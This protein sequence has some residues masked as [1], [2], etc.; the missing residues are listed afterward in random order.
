MAG[1]H[2]FD[3]VRGKNVRALPEERVRRQLV[4][5][6][7]ASVGVPPRL[8]AVEYSLSHLVPLSRKRADVVVWRPATGQDGGL[9]PWLLAECK[10]P[11]VALTE[12]VADQVR[13]YAA[14]LRAEH[15]LVTNGTGTRCFRLEF[16]LEG[17][18]YAELE[19]L[20]PFDGTARAD[21]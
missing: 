10:A 12:A 21:S 16:G 8:I 20:P 18:R 2:L 4:D 17:A 19:N 5:W 11:G 7:T 14:M 13:G 6:L 9:R 15:V 1:E 3:P